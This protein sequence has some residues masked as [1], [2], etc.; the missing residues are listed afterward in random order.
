MMPE[1]SLFC[2]RQPRRT[3][4]ALGRFRRLV[5]QLLGRV[6]VIALDGLQIFVVGLRQ[7][8]ARSAVVRLDLSCRGSLELGV[9]TVPSL[10]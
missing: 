9:D 4:V 3:P 7:R 1:I 2:A 10:W 5:H 8:I 6:K